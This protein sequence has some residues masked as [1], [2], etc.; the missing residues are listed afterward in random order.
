MT[1]N[2]TP[3]TVLP[4]PSTRTRP[5]PKRTRRTRTAEVVTL[6]APRRPSTPAPIVPI[7]PADEDYA[8]ARAIAGGYFR[9]PE[10]AKEG[11]VEL[12]ALYAETDHEGQALILTFARGCILRAEK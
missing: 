11:M 6:P 10:Y 2:H 9:L 3:T 8:N 4:F 12:A 5:A 1:G 7:L